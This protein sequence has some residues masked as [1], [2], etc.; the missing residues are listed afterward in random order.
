LK[1]KLTPALRNKLERKF[2]NDKTT[3]VIR[4]AALGMLCRSLPDLV[5]M[6]KD[7]TVARDLA[8]IQKYALD[9]SEGLHAIADLMAQAS[10]DIG[11]ALHY[12]QERS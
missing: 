12:A 6:A 1:P 2:A 9:Y 5:D 4:R 3:G 10:R 7:K 11:F 8:D